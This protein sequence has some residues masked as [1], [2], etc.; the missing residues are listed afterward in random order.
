MPQSEL[1]DADAYDSRDSPHRTISVGH[2]HRTQRL[3][4][5]WLASLAVYAILIP[6]EWLDRTAATYITD[7]ALAFG[8]LLVAVSCTRAARASRGREYFAWSCF[9]IAAAC[10]FVGQ[11]IWNYYELALR[12]PPPVPSPVDIGFVLFG[13]FMIA[14]VLVL[15][16]T[17]PSRRLTP[18]R[19]ANLGL[20]LC[21]LA[22]VL[23]AL[24]APPLMRLHHLLFDSLIIVAESAAVTIAL[25]V[26]VY[27]LWSYRWG[28]RL[29]P[30]ALLTLALACVTF[31]AVI[32][33]R[34]LVTGT[35]T[36]ES[37]ANLA[38]LLA[39]ALQQCAAEVQVSVCTES[40]RALPVP[41]EERQGWVE[42]LVPAFLIL[43]LSA[44]AMANAREFTPAIVRLC[45][46]VLGAF[47][48]VLALR[49][50][51][52]YAR[53]LQTQT[54]LDS[55]IRELADAREQ[56]RQLNTRRTELEQDVDLMARAGAVGL[57]DWDLRSNTVKFSPEWK[58]QLGYAEHELA[59]DMKEW[60][61]RVHPEDID[62]MIDATRRYL[63]DPQGDF[64]A[65]HR[66]RHRDG[67]YRWIL[68]HATVL[69]GADG[70][71][72]RMLGSHV[73]I[74]E[75]KNMELSLRQSEAQLR[76]LANTLETRVA[77]R[78][79]ELTEAYRESESFAYAVAHDLKA[80]LRAID[81]FSHLLEQSVGPRLSD[82][83]RDYVAR[84]RRAAVHMASLIDDLL[85][86]SRLEHRELRF[87]A[88]DCRELVESVLAPMDPLIHSARAI[89]NVTVDR[90]RV[91]ADAE[92]LRIVIRN[93]VDNALKFASPKRTPQ[94]EIGSYLDGKHCV[95]TVRDNGI[96]FDPK[97]K[98]KIFEI[99]QRLHATGYEGTG[100]GLAL[101][102]KALQRMNGRIW[103]ESEVDCGST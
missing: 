12:V 74:T 82:T 9:A 2:L 6:T 73:D 83:E 86:Y 93:L 39:C 36:A 43:C 45:G 67:S 49:E 14:G 3:A 30:L 41:A 32:F 25:I 8:A 48:V 99:F 68:S 62:R 92:G 61:T 29:V 66:L 22:L 101:V 35:F 70:K 26:A 7:F 85:A 34:E 100:I 16:S 24:L 56:L 37:S 54:R 81:G 55:T 50:S 75:R 42:A 69:L 13:S 98:D 76:E 94:I 47:A 97:Y 31:G 89:V 17:L 77:E 10:W 95:L 52:R 15:R 103:V 20:I 53:G 72:R 38:W 71:P 90:T 40:E 84:V 5:V 80:P 23:V 79:R 33:T 46:L 18:L 60:R 11:L 78:T 65:E 88:I 58:R 87:D 102:R 44:I 4:V 91:Y 21:S 63:K 51:L 27:M 64:I 1:K 28:D 59:D 57:F 96:G 19:I